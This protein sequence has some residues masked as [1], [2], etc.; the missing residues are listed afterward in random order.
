MGFLGF[1]FFAVVYNF[2]A[3]ILD[4]FEFE[5]KNTPDEEYIPSKRDIRMREV[6]G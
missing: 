1:D 3:G 6:Y 5:I 4:G 2:L